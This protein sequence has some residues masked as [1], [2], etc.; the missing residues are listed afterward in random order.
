ME[1]AYSK[2]STNVYGIN[3]SIHSNIFFKFILKYLSVNSVV[4]GMIIPFGQLDKMCTALIS[5]THSKMVGY[6]F[7]YPY[8]GSSFQM[9]LL[10]RLTLYVFIMN[11]IEYELT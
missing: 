4:A 7:K 10:Q 11:V 8:Q 9:Q 1:L 3:E 2:C 5:I 6:H